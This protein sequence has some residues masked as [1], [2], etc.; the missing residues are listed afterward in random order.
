MFLH[1]AH[2]HSFYSDVIFHCMI[3]LRLIFHGHVD[4]YLDHF[5][6]IYVLFYDKHCCSEHS[7]LSKSESFSRT[8]TPNLFFLIN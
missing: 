4:E 5:L 6:L 7:S 2:I 1:V 3:I 8:V